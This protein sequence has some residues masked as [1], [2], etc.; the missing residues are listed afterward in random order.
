VEY[1]GKVEENVKLTWDFSQGIE[2]ENITWDKKFKMSF[3]F[4]A[5]GR[6]DDFCFSCIDFTVLGYF[7]IFH[8][9]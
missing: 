7:I 8:T 6:S 1:F 4:G 2:K 9:Q 5:D 3:L